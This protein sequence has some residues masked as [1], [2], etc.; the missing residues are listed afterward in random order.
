[1]RVRMVVAILAALIGA[2]C[3]PV[4]KPGGF[5]VFATNETGGTLTT[6]DGLSGKVLAV[7]P[8]GKR[9]RGLAASPDGRWLYIA[10]SGSPIAPPGVNEA[11]L[12]PPDKSADGVGVF[13]V[14]AGRLQRVLK[15]VSDPEQVAASPDG[16]RVYVASEDAASLVI[17]DPRS[18]AVVGKVL[19]GQEPEG[20]AVSP[21][22][23]LVLVTLEDE[24]VV[25][26]VDPRGQKVVGRIPVGKRP[27]SV[28]IAHDGASAFVS[29][30]ASAS[31]ARLDLGKRS[32]IARAQLPDKGDKPMGLALSSDGRTLFVTTGRGGHVLALDANDLH[33]TGSAAIGP[34]PWGVAVSPDGRRLYTADGPADAV[35]VLD[36]V[37]LKPIEFLTSKGKPWGVVALR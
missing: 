18:G 20:V 25:A 7:T 23:G 27:R 19:V 11:D 9:P 35:A 4:A 34:R 15:G 29:E 26:I 22:G 36:A 12:P 33:T 2:G 32:L 37:T 16:S 13:D 14:A 5:R 6:I 21:D 17:L 10:L 24:G 8:L 28:L 3:Q 1:M 30:E 31:V